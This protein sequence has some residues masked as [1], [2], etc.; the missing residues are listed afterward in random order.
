MSPDYPASQRFAPPA[1]LDAALFTLRRACVHARNLTLDPKADVRQVNSLMEAIHEV[2]RFL[3]DWSAERLPELRL[4][5]SGF[6]HS[7]WPGAL[8]LIA[9]FDTRLNANEQHP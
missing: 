6:D 5:L 3:A 1:V 9:T 2:P 7:I 4:H 8:S